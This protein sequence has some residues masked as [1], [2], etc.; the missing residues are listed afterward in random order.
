[1][2][3][4]LDFGNSDVRNSRGAVEWITLECPSVLYIVQYVSNSHPIYIHKKL[5]WLNSRGRFEGFDRVGATGSALAGDA[6]MP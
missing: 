6:V 4:K 1:M 2:G 5:T 3:T